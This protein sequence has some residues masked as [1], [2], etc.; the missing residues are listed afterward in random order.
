MMSNSKFFPSEQLPM[1]RE[2][3]LA[4]DDSKFGMLQTI[5]YKDPGTMIIVSVLAGSF[6]LD[7]FLIGNTGLGVGKLLTCGGIG[8]WTIVD[9]FNIQSATRALNLAKI[10]PYLY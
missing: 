3:L 9:W 5:S 4:L 1:L 10:Q 2:R 8:I 6:G 7:R